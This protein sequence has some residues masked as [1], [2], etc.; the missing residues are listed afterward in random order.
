MWSAGIQKLQGKLEPSAVVGMAVV[1]FGRVEGAVPIMSSSGDM[2]G[3]V[4]CSGSDYHD[5]EVQR[6]N[7]LLTRF[8]L[9]TIDI[10][11]HFVTG[12]KSEARRTHLDA[13]S[14]SPLVFHC[15]SF[16]NL[17]NDISQQGS[18]VIFKSVSAFDW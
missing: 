12:R 11:I 6:L 1:S 9:G 15:E 14:L 4:D 18:R 7:F 13:I 10:S 5:K 17:P 3:D 8:T 2:D 16:S